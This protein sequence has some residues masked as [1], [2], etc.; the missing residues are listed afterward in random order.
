MR[1]SLEDLKRINNLAPI[2]MRPIEI[3]LELLKYDAIM[4]SKLE[5]YK[6]LYGVEVA[7][8]LFNMECENK[9]CQSKISV[10][11][12]F[13]KELLDEVKKCSD[14]QKLINDTDQFL[15]RSSN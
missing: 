1:L 8:K 4:T 5:S 12:Y 15:E 2:R 3:S 9:V 11:E 10:C 6:L 7:N 14:N 13:I